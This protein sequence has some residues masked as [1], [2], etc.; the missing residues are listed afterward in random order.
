MYASTVT[1]LSGLV[2]AG[3]AH[4]IWT[5]TH[6]AFF[7]PL[8]KFRGPKTVSTGWYKAWQELI[9]SMNW[10]YVLNELHK[11]YGEV[12]RVG[13]NEVNARVED[14]SNVTIILLC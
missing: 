14:N 13:P 4:R 5:L 3:A 8:A 11:Q 2:I 12:V 9:R 6:Y 1:L 10:F 7:H